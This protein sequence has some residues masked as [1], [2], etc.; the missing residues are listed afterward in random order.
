ML[1]LRNDY[2]DESLAIAEL[3]ETA[4]NK[5]NELLNPKYQYD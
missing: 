2:S 5:N 1:F 4:I 3:L